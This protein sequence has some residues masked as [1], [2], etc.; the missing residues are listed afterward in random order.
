MVE[1]NWMLTLHI[2]GLNRPRLSDAAITTEP[3]KGTL[4]TLYRLLATIEGAIYRTVTLP[5]LPKSL[6]TSGYGGL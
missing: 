5:D 2:P 1:F 4:L 3:F 6:Q